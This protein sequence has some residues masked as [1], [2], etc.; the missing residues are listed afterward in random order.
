[1]IRMMDG[2]RMFART[3]RL[4][5]QLNTMEIDTSGTRSRAESKIGDS[6]QYTRHKCISSIRQM[7]NKRDMDLILSQND[8]HTREISA[9]F[10]PHRGSSGT[11]FPEI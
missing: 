9:P 3:I 11:L 7:L 1:M 8:T 4:W 6:N 2:D 5:L 10:I